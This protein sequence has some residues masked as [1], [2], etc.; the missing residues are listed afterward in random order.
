MGIRENFQGSTTNPL[1]S[2][3]I[4]TYRGAVY[5]QAA[6]DSVLAQTLNDLELVVIDDNS[7]DNTSEIVAKYTDSRIRY[8]RNPVNLGPEGNWNRC[9]CEARGTYFKLLPQDDCLYPDA[10][11]RQVRVLAE[12]ASENIALVFGSRTILG[13]AG[14]SLMQRG[15]PWGKEGRVPSRELIRRCVRFGTNLIGEPGS[16]LM[17]RRL[18]DTVGSFDGSIPYIIDLDYWVRLLA[19]GD[20]YYLP[21]PVAAF[22]VSSGSWSVAI[23]RSQG[24][25]FRRFV[26]RYRQ[27]VPQGLSALDTALGAITSRINN[28]SRLAVYRFALK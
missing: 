21:D 3:C 8:L 25:D 26:A 20:G 6:L 9:L 24:R 14:R 13:S 22:R 5:L 12:D 15:Y 18:A 16:V 27:R 23:G 17:R 2:V 10:L 1:V 4:P 11:A 28:V 7:P 19:H